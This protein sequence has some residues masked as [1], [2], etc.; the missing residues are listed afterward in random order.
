MFKKGRKIKK[1]TLGLIDR[2]NEIIQ[3]LT[4]ENM[5]LEDENEQ[6]R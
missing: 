6:A 3:D 2:K 4:A 5:N 1:I